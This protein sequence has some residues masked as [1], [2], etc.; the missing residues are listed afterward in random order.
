MPR[1][2]PGSTERVLA[3]TVPA[4]LV[5]GTATFVSY[6]IARAAPGTTGTQARTTAMLA[7]F[8]FGLWVVLLVARLLDEWRIG[9]VA[10]MVGGL[11]L[12]FGFPF[13][14]RLFSLQ[15]PTASVARATP[16]AVAGG[17]GALAPW[18]AWAADRP[19]APPLVGREPWPFGTSNTEP[20]ER[21]KPMTQ[22]APSKIVIG[23]DG[24]E[25]S[26]KA[27]EW[28]IRQA[29]LTGA[30]SG[31]RHGLGVYRGAH[32]VRHRASRLTGRRSF[33]GSPRQ[34]R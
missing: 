29:E 5:I 23:M 7:A 1:S 16:F 34:A 22:A 19:G 28:A 24:S 27:L 15:F 13:T 18:C 32:T 12:L 3:F 10:A 20:F 30:H 21:D 33:V 14:R 31:H 25:S 4:G 8:A 11:F 2:S 6:A 17:I 26:E 9:L